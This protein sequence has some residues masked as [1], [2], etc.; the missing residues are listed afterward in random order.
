MPVID[1]SVY[2]A[3]VNPHEVDHKRSRSWLEG[4]LRSG[5]SLYA[6]V[7]ILGEVAAAISRGQD[8]Q[9]GAK[10]AVNTLKRSR[11]F[12]LYAVSLALADRAAAIA[13]E[14]K[15]RGCDALYVALAEALDD[16][17]V[18]LDQQQQKRGAAVVSTRGP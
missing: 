2:V 14:H 7:I 9:D 16:E 15:I 12:G 18:T 13:L 1:A 3:L 8:N 10:R 4:V 17:L 5:E 6:P 11:A